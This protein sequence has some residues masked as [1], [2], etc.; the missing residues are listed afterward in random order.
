MREPPVTKPQARGAANAPQRAVLP[1]RPPSGFGRH[2]QRGHLGGPLPPA[3]TALPL[4]PHGN[5]IGRRLGRR[6]SADAMVD[7]EGCA[8]VGVPAFTTMGRSHFATADPPLNIAAHE[9]AHVLQQTGA[10]RD[11]GLGAE[12]H[13]ATLESRVVR[14]DDASGLVGSHGGAPGRGPHPYTYVKTEDQTSGYWQAGVGLRVADDGKMATGDGAKGS[15]DF[16]ASVDRLKESNAILKSVGSDFQLMPHPSSKLVGTAPL[17]GS[18]NLLFRISPINFANLT[19]GSSMTTPDDCGKVAGGVMGTLNFV[20]EYKKVLPASAQGLPPSQTWYSDPNVMDKE[21][22]TGAMNMT[23]PEKAREQ[24]DRLSP[25]DRGRF[26]KMVG[27]NKYA[28]VKTGEAFAIAT[29]PESQRGDWKF[30]IGGVVMTSGTDQVTLE[31]YAQQPG[32]E[33]TFQMYGTVKEGQTFH[34]QH[35]DT[36]MHG[37]RPITMGLHVDK[38]IDR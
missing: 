6:F 28:K 33:W 10:T 26:D 3:A 7:V 22:L 30:H 37:T 35:F 16:W 13:A 4:Y 9:A 15:K 19:L 25:E 12:G 2:L 24:Y 8:R 34:E 18:K 32:S 27:I 29:G 36:D 20:A 14:G 23:D 17:D 5:E 31:N 11:L 21:V 1:V 38:S